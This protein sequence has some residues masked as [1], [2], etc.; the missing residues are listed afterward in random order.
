MLRKVFKY[1][2][3]NFPAQ[4][5]VVNCASL[6]EPVSHWMKTTKMFDILENI[7][8]HSKNLSFLW[9]WMVGEIAKVPFEMC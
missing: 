2:K 6:S 9:N 7:F 8:L 5:G 4:L 3:V 1:A